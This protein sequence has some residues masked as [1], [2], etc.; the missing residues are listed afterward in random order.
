MAAPH[1]QVHAL[2]EGLEGRGEAARL[3]LEIG[4]EGDDTLAPGL[5]EPRGE[6]GRGAE[7][8][9]EQDDD[10]LLPR[11]LLGIG[12]NALE[13][14][15]G[16]A[17][18]LVDDEEELCRPAEPREL[19][20]K[21]VIKLL[22][23]PVALDHGDDDGNIRGNNGIATQP[24]LSH[25]GGPPEWDEESKASVSLKSPI[26]TTSSENRPTIIK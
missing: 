25:R 19:V 24:P 9:A 10:D 14:G 13:R 3:D 6:R 2:I 15:H 18:L 21:L 22:Q 11:I 1:Y 20:R 17:E 23:I 7:G 4:G 5:G 16:A 26:L 12:L 8:A